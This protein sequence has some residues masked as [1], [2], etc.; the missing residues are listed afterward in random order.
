LVLVFAVG[1][2]TSCAAL[3]LIEID[4]MR[5]SITGSGAFGGITVTFRATL[6]NAVSYEWDFGDGGT[7]AGQIISHLYSA[8]GQ[9]TVTLV[10]TTSQD[11]ITVSKIVD[12]ITDVATAP[13]STPFGQIS[14]TPIDTETFDPGN[15]AVGATL[16]QVGNGVYAVAYDGPSFQGNI[17]TFSVNVGGSGEIINPLIDNFIFGNSSDSPDVVEVSSG[18][19]AISHAGPGADGFVT[20]VAIDGAGN[21]TSI[22]DTIEF[23]TGSGTDTSIAHVIGDIYAVAFRGPS[24]D[25]FLRTIEIDSFGMMPNSH[26][27]TVEFDTVNVFEPD[28]ISVGPGVVA[29]FYTGS[30][31]QG[32]V[33]TYAIDGSGNITNTPEDSLLFSPTNTG[34]TVVEEVGTGVYAVAYT[35]PGNDGFVSTIDI[36]SSGNIGSVIDNFEFEP[37]FAFVVTPSITSAGNGV[38]AIAFSTLP[39]VRLVTVAIDA[40]GDI[41]P[42]IIDSLTVD[43]SGGD[44]DVISIGNDIYAIAYQGPGSIGRVVTVQID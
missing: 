9:Y 17:T 28:M 23:H 8:E 21:I 36:D 40:S 6:D 11:V 34:W 26:E 19:Y 3:T 22:I 2:T 38:Y 4:V 13:S 41:G 29:I 31:S 1:F 16:F 18:I 44:P 33:V 32:I 20:T 10:I 25:G 14:D 12:I 7:G 43:A 24:A 39:G 35:G 5:V 27:D 42:T 15:R 30:S 37:S